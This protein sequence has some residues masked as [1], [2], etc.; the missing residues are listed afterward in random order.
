[1]SPEK[2]I[3]GIKPVY[4]FKFIRIGSRISVRVNTIRYNRMCIVHGQQYRVMRGKSILNTYI[5]SQN[6]I[7]WIG[8]QG[9]SI[10]A[11]LKTDRAIKKLITGISVAMGVPPR[12]HDGAETIYEWI[13]YDKEK[14]NKRETK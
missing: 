14:Y 2:L 11:P 8:I 6:G 13:I 5:D 9:D 4:L 12:I 1:M 10:I 7:Q 3:I